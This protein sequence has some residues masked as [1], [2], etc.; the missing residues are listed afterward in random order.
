MNGDLQKETE[1]NLL[2][3]NNTDLRINADLLIDE[4][5]RIG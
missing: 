2:G 5:L 1:L 3:L 4:D